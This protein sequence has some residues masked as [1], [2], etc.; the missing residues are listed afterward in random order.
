MFIIAS[1]SYAIS[2]FIDVF[3]YHLK[4]NIHD[5]NNVRY[6]FSLINIFQFSARAFVL[7]FIPIM[8]YYTETVKDKHIV[9]E[10]TLLSHLFVVI[11]L[12]P[13]YSNKFSH[14]FSLNIIKILNIIFG[15]SKKI[16][17]EKFEQIKPSETNTINKSK[18]NKFYFVSFTFISGFMFS[19][20][21]TFL[22]YLSFSYPQKALT[23]T[24][25]SQILNMIGVLLLVLLID[26]RIMSSIDKGE[27]SEEIK[28]LTT[29]RILVHI[30]LV[31]IL[32]LIK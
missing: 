7:I 17:F 15:K 26:P 9:W 16:S 27:G 23:L 30:T 18:F 13:L 28:L 5:N 20:S 19:Y 24:S 22:Y 32:F 14:G 8:A 12:L 25:Y 31:I 4:L 1:I 11:I 29:S 3:A 10:I 21:I 6:L 2:I